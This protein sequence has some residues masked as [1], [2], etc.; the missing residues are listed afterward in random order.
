SPPLSTLFPYTT[1]FRSLFATMLHTGILG[2][3]LTLSRQVWYPAQAAFAA[4]WGLTPLEDQQLAGLVMWVP[5][6]L[7]YTAAA[8]A[9]AARWRSEEHTSE[10]QLRGQLV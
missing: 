5:M 9:I 8:L 4:E 2:I 6:G 3:L 10:L 1:L 7:I